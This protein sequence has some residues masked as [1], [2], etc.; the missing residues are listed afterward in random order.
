MT[1]LNSLRL[2]GRDGADGRDDAEFLL[3]LL[4]ATEEVGPDAVELIDEGD[5]RHVMLVRLIPDRFRLHLDAADGAEDA[6]RPVQH[7]QG[8]FDLG[9]EIDVAGRVDDGNARIAPFDGDGGAVDG[10]A[11]GRS[12]GSKSVVVLPSSTSPT[13]CLDPLK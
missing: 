11:L 1:P 9:R 10:D 6:D 7:A 3:H 2:P 8:A 13:L 5:A 12:S 4:D